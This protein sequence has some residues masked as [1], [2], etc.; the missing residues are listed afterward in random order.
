MIELTNEL[1]QELLD[2]RS[3]KNIERLA[4]I[5][6]NQPQQLSAIQNLI[7]E[8]GELIPNRASWLLCEVQ[9]ID[10]SLT[11]HLVED[12]VSLLPMLHHD[13]NRRNLMKFFSRASLPHKNL[14]LLL[15]LAF[16]W[17]SDPTM[18]IAVR[19][20]C[21]TVIH[22]ISSL[23]PDIIPEFKLLLKECVRT[24]SAGELSRAR[25]ILK[26]LG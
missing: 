12:L 13:G 11:N 2:D 16:E 22:R 15:Q 8:E 9:Q 6:S 3:K 5:I 20:H 23:E 7:Q 17:L 10:P 24:G 26:L 4:Q 1:R 18:A 21:M 14:G 19:A 25:K